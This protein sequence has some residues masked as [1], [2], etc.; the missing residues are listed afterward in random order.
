ML[1]MPIWPIG[2]ALILALGGLP[3]TT[4]ANAQTSKDEIVRS[5]TPKGGFTRSI[6]TRKIEVIPGKEAEVLDKNKNL[7]KIN[8]TIEFEYEF[9]TAERQRR[10]A[11]GRARRGPARPAAERLSF[12]AGGT[13]RCAR[14]RRVQPK[15]VGASRPSRSG[16]P[17]RHRSARRQSIENRR[18]RRTASPGA[19]SPG[20]PTQPARRGHQPTQLTEKM[21]RQAGDRAGQEGNGAT[22]EE[23]RERRSID[24]TP[25]GRS[26]NRIGSNGI[27]KSSGKF[28]QSI[29]RQCGNRFAVRKCD[30]A[31]R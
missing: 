22:G 12:P 24:Q 9:R 2:L 28:D 20:Q 6:R 14:V 30:K 11:T 1:R 23:E 13:Y 31:K 3:L 16:L 26:Q 5:L 7:P 4:S 21:A 27:K 19:R 25:I 10:I 15:T 17:R 8:L 29:S 18:L